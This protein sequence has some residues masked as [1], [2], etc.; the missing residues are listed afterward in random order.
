MSKKIKK[1]NLF[2]K[3][4]NSLLYAYGDVAQPLPETVQCVDDLLSGYL[5]DICTSAYRASRATGKNKVKLEDF[6]FVI[7]RD[8]IKLARASEL[9]STNKLITEA[10]K[11]FNE[12]DNQNAKR[13]RGG[14]EEEED[15]EEEEEEDEDA[16]EDDDDENDHQPQQSNIRRSENKS[17]QKIRQNK[18][19]KQAN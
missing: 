6:K 3:D 1:T 2:S 4:V 19:Q 10:K 11:Q 7:R 14:E 18:K 16:E 12:N 15:D 8:P 5:V 17:G 9:I 13:F